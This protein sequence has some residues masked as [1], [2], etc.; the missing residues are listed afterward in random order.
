MKN[1]FFS[2]LI[3]GLLPLAGMKAQTAA[4]NSKTLIG[5]KTSVII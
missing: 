4:L 5:N 2:A 3:A 1:A